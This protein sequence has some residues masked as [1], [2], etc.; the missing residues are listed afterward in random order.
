V[1]RKGCTYSPL[2]SIHDKGSR[3]TDADTAEEHCDSLVLISTAGNA[4]GA[5]SCRLL[6]L[7][8]KRLRVG[9]DRMLEVVNLEAGL[10][11][12]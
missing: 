3:A 1:V 8:Q 4:E 12:V 7:A 9:S 5:R 2:H 6:W 11:Y 10:D